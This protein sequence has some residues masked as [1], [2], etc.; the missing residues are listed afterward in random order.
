MLRK[1]QKQQKTKES[2]PRAQWMDAL[3]LVQVVK[4]A[5]KETGI[6]WAQSKENP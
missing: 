6:N 3:G 2:H 4:K 1:N 5:S